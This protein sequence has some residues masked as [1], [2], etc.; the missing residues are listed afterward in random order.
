VAFDRWIGRVQ[1][2]EA[3]APEPHVQV[4]AAAMCAM[5]RAD[6]GDREGA[7]AELLR[8]T[9]RLLAGATPVL[10][11]RLLLVE[12]DLLRRTGDVDRAIDTLA[13]LC[14]PPRPHIAYAYARLHLGAGD[15]TAAIEVMKPYPVERAT[16][17]HRVEGG[18]IHT[19]IAANGDRHHALDP[20]ENALLAAAPLGLRRPFLVEASE[21]AGLLGERIEA[22]T[23]AAAFAV[24]L[25]RRM[26][27]GPTAAPAMP[28]VALTE[29]EHVVL[30]YMAS[31]LSNAEIAAELYLSVNTIK[32]HQRMVYRKLGA[33]G[34]RDAVRRAR[35]LRIL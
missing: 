20:L 28:L 25:V 26:T 16:V 32:S 13:R 22:G 10:A 8:T 19:L 3:I 5:R 2:V 12:A 33:E 6:A 27:G 31:T 29:R 24:D 9:G 34:R 7:L 15:I 1:E 35:E 14:G 23:G 17:R 18:I 11:D 4:A 21:L 30:R